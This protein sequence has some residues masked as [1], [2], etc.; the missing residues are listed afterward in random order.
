LLRVFAGVEFARGGF[1][2]EF[3]DDGAVEADVLGF[4]G[5]FVEIIGEVHAEAGGVDGA[6]GEFA[7]FAGVV[8]D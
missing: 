2:L 5:D 8:E 3:L 6:F 4:A 1:D 7:E